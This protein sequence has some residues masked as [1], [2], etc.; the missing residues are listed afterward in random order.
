MRIYTDNKAAVFI[1]E[2]ATAVKRSKAD[3]RHAVFLQE[4]VEECLVQMKH[5]PGSDNVADIFTKWLARN[6]F[7]K[8]RAVLINMHAHR[9]LGIDCP[10]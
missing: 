1:A 4:A 10:S 3:S 6:K 9:K 2:D 8:F 7:E 5:W